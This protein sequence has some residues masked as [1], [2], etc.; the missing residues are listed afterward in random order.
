MWRKTH[1]ARILRALALI[2]LLAVHG[3][4][5]AAHE[6]T[7]LDA[8]T[9]VSCEFCA[10]GSTLQHAA[11]DNATAELPPRWRVKPEQARHL[12]VNDDS[13]CPFQA[14]APPLSS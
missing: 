4:G 12:V 3:T 2:L 14:R 8:T 7:H 10:A 1:K 5:L 13:H 6:A 11:V 9:S